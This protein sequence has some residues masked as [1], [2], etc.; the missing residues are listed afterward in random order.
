MKYLLAL[1]FAVSVAQ[2]CYAGAVFDPNTGS[3]AP[4]AGEEDSPHKVQQRIDRANEIFGEAVYSARILLT[5]NEMRQLRKHLPYAKAVMIFPSLLSGGFLL[6]AKGGSGVLV[7]RIGK[8]WSNPA[9]M[10]LRAVSF[11]LQIGGEKQEAIFLVMTDRGLESVLEGNFKLGVDVS[12]AAFSE[13]I[14]ASAAT[15]ASATD[16]YSF[17]KSSGVYAGAGFEGA[18]VSPNAK[19]NEAFYGKQV[20]IKELIYAPAGKQASSLKQ[21]LQ[22][23]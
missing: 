11:G 17:S 18:I 19:L 22:D 3:V 16:I 1:I 15:T 5:S 4:E 21:V 23:Y 14:G 13:G 9:F 10:D 2:P 6:G 12:V 8:S 7:A 20:A